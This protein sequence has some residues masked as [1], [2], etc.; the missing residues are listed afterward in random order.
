M[1]VSPLTPTT[2]W[3]AERAIANT[4]G[5]AAATGHIQALD[6]DG[7]GEIGLA[8][9]EA[10]VLASSF[11]IPVALEYARRVA[12]GTVDPNE[13]VA[14]A[15]EDRVPGPT[16]LSGFK[17]DA[18]VSL[19]D[20]AYLM[21]TLSDNTAT[22]VMI[23]KLGLDRVNS[24]LGSLGLTETVLVGDCRRIIQELLDDLGLDEDA[25]L[26][27]SAT[28]PQVVTGA[29]SL[30]PG[31]TTRSTPREAAR[32]VQMIWRDEAGPPE[33]CAEVRR[34][35]RAQVWRDRLQSGFPDEVVVSGKTGTLPGG[36]ATRSGP[37]SIP[38]EG[39]TRWRSS[40]PPIASPG[41]NRRSTAPS[42][43]RRGWRW[44]RC[45]PGTEGWVRSRPA[46]PG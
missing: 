42:G 14:V 31:K 27:S 11:K 30:R 7:D 38:M 6:V 37:W 26:D 4:F 43:G 17:H 25:E 3:S 1:K 9:D 2:R 39:V 19:G 18:V 35:M 12:A 29:R 15:S 8:A 22:D 36:S 45:A 41:G 32:L 40:R 24:L 23:R 21:M 16:G 28:D 46:R 44:R 5:A 10:V 33:A 34:L 20:L 13:R